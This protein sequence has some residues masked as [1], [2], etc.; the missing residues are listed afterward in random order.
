MSVPKRFKTHTQK[1]GKKP[2]NKVFIKVNLI[3][4]ISLNTSM[5]SATKFKNV[6]SQTLKF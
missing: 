5:L 6:N 3:N 2:I 1:L 4:L